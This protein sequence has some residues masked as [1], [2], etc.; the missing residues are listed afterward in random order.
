MSTALQ[1]KPRIIGQKARICIV[2]SKYNEPF[3]DSLVTNAIEELSEL[4]PLARIDIV[5]VPGAFEIPVTVAKLTQR[6]DVQC[7]IALG[8]I[9]R[10][11]TQHADLIATSVTQ[12]LQDIAV[13]H[14]IPVIHEVLLVN[15]EKQAHARCIAASM[16]RGREAA[17]AAV[18]MIDIF[19]EI[20]KSIPRSS[21]N[22]S[23]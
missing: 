12:S 22:K 10:G 13:N 20:D 14:C 21:P 18:G 8:L 1:P 6:P 17:K 11:D 2:A 9:I 19:M 3:T 4:S 7:I 16:N 15:D 5:R 23:K